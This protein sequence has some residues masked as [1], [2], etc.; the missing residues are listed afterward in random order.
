MNEP[1]V[2]IKWLHSS[3]PSDAFQMSFWKKEKEKE[4]ERC[5]WRF[6]IS[7]M[8][9]ENNILILFFPNVFSKFIYINVTNL[10][11]WGQMFSHPRCTL[12]DWCFNLAWLHCNK[13]LYHSFIRCYIRLPLSLLWLYPMTLI[14]TTGFWASKEQHL[15]FYMYANFLSLLVFNWQM[16]SIWIVY[17]G[18]TVVKN[19][20]LSFLH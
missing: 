3:P 14:S 18:F 19:T 7:G 12:W 17:P 10:L 13:L 20:W 4:R 16:R 1:V 6:V 15:H 8:K 5:R 9:F 11:R 2:R